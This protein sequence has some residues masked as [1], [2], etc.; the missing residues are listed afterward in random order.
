MCG[1]VAG[2]RVSRCMENRKI[3][4]GGIP[5]RHDR[6]EKRQNLSLQRLAAIQRGRP[7]PY[8]FSRAMKEEGTKKSPRGLRPDRGEKRD[9]RSPRRIMNFQTVL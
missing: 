4:R 3:T 9:Q 7:F 2:W 6:T 8:A 1:G 5:F